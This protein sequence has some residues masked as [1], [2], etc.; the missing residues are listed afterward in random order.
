MELDTLRA[1]VRESPYHSGMAMSLTDASN[2]RATMQLDVQS[3]H[4]SADGIVHGGVVAGLLDSV[5]WYALHTTRD[6]ERACLTAQLNVHYLHPGRPP[7]LI[8]SGTSA[9]DGR[10]TAVAYGEVHDEQGVLI[11]TGSITAV[12]VDA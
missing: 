12:S 11:A 5:C 1:R 8:A 3:H 2:G 10:R 6:E 4:L 7:R 9:H